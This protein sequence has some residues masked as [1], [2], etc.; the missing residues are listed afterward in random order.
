MAGL[1]LA[2]NSGEVTLVAATPKTILQVKAPANQRLKIANISILGKS[3]AGG[4]DTPVKVRVT[5]STAS[6]GTGTA[7]T[8]SKRNPSDPETIQSTAFANF[9]VEPTTPTDGGVWWEVQPQSGIIQFM[10]PEYMMEVPG[11]QSLNLEATSVATPTLLCVIQ[12]EE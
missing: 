11:G 3:P 5:R 8:P 7:A 1:K 2:V 10:P 6:F 9:T 4:T 12:Y